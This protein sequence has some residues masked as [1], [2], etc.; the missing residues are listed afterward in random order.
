ML[1]LGLMIDFRGILG[2]FDPSAA[3]AIFNGMLNSTPVIG[4]IVAAIGLMTTLHGLIRLLAGRSEEDEAK[5]TGFRDA[6][7]R[8][9]GVAILLVGLAVA[10]VGFFLILAPDALRAFLT[11]LAGSVV[12]P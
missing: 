6:V 11:T 3:D 2:F 12:G 7:Y 5:V 4:V 8:L 1:G 9:V 10:I